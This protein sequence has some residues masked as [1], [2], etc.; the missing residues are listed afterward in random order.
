MKVS[1]KKP[2]NIRPAFIELGHLN[3][4][5]RNYQTVICLLAGIIVAQ[6]CFALGQRDQLS[7]MRAALYVCRGQLDVIMRAL[8]SAPQDD[9]AVMQQNYNSSEG[10]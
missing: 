3:R 2:L 7:N 1:R 4:V 9:G 5:R 10:V 6:G 8:D